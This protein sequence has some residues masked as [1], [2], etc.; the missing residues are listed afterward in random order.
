VLST[1]VDPTFRFIRLDWDG[2]I[3]M[4]CSSPHAMAGLIENK[5]RFDV[6]FACDTDH[7][8]H[9]IV[10]RSGGLMNPNHYLAVAIEYLFTHRPGWSAEAGIGK[11]LVSS[12]M[13]DRVAAGIERRLV[14][15]PVGFKWFVDGLMD[16]SLGF[17]G[18]ES[19]GASFLDKQA[20]IRHR[21]R[22]QDLRRELRRRSAPGAHSGRGQ[23]AGGFG[24]GRLR[25]N[26]RR[27]ASGFS[28]WRSLI[29]TASC[30]AST[31]SVR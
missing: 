11:T 13:I 19:A 26:A 4:D 17:G 21:G 25:T 31:S 6:A 24:A 14:E 2:K 30:A 10:T 8:R 15:V 29:L 22:P 23:G 3:R 18:E 1:V 20:T 9:G 7:D 28:C 5:D 16:G 12:S 27:Q